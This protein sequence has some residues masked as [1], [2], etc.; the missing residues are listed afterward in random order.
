MMFGMGTLM[1]EQ[2]VLAEILCAEAIRMAEKT[3]TYTA[4]D[5]LPGIMIELGLCFTKRTNHESE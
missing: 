4:A 2:N 5:E 3:P 1:N